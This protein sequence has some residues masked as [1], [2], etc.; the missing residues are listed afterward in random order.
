MLNIEE[1]RNYCIK[2]PGVSESFPFDES[3]LV[4]KVSDKMFALVN[5]DGDLSM[6]LKCDPERAILLR[7]KYSFVIPGYHMNKRHWNT[8]IIDNNVPGKLVFEWIDHSYTLVTRT[9]TKEKQNKL[10]N[11]NP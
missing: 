10:K 11:L 2:K 5:L 1:L 3:T 7:E 6:N 4:F 9:L 8:V